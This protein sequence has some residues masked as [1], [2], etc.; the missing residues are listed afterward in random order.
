M[1]TLTSGNI[2]TIAIAILALLGA[3]VGTI[4]TM[5]NSKM[6]AILEKTKESSEEIDRLEQSIHDVETGELKMLNELTQH[7]IRKEDCDT[8]HRLLVA[9]LKNEQD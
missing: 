5:L 1:I 7:F 6:N 8:Q 2:I 9:E 3:L 4:W